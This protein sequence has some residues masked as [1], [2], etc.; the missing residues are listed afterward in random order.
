MDQVLDVINNRDDQFLA[1]VFFDLSFFIIV[2][3]FI[4]NIIT[5]LI[6]DTFGSLREEAAARADQLDNECY[7]CG[8]TRTSYDDIGMISP[9]F[10]QH[11]VKKKKQHHI[12]TCFFLFFSSVYPYCSS[13]FYSYSRLSLSLVC[14]LLHIYSYETITFGTTCTSSS[15]S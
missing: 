12:H 14:A 6:V 9:S 10:D 3:V 8:F 4:F 2:G 15:T 1:R 7:V 13:S 5:G 11:K